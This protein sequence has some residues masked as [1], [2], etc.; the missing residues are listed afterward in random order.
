MIAALVWRSLRHNAR[1]FGAILG[2][3]VAFEIFLVQL[4][5]AFEEGPG[6]AEMLE[7]LPPL[8][9]NFLDSY[10]SNLGD[11][12]LPSFVAFG[13]QHPAVL[14]PSVALVILT[15]TIPSGDREAG[16]LELFLARPLPRARYL[17]SALVVLG[18]AALALPLCVLIGAAIGLALV[19]VPGEPSWTAYVGTALESSALLLALGG[20]SLWMAA[21]APRRGAAVAR[22]V[23]VLLP[24]YVVDAFS[25]LSNFLNSLRWISPFNYFNPIQASLGREPLGLNLA[26]LLGLFAVTSA[27]AFRVFARRD[28]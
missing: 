11:F 2:G 16:T 13:F 26:V 5:V 8:L 9:R 27:L 20:F 28:I 15:A 14:V 17:A 23:G 21:F 4:A 12:S 10:A 1:L 7:M 24:L 19:S 18:I 6:I 25:Q 22:I 3:L